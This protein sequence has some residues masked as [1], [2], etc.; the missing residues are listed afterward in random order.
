L[1]TPSFDAS[2]NST[3][4]NP[5]NILNSLVYQASPNA[6]IIDIVDA[7]REHSEMYR[8]GDTHL[9]DPGNKIAGEYGREKLAAL[10]TTTAL[11][12]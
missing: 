5:L 12:T 8:I 4:S 6:P 11:G 7:L 2:S 10:L 1:Q 9:S 3:P